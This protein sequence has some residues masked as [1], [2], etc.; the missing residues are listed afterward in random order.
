MN[1]KTALIIALL[2]LAP[3]ATVG[4]VAIRPASAVETLKVGVIGPYNLPQWHK[5]QGGMEGGALLA[6]LD[7]LGL[8]NV[9][10][11]QYQVEL[12]FADEHAYP[13]DEDAAYN[14]AMALCEEG[15]KFIIGGFRTEVTWKIIYAIRDWNEEHPDNEVIFLINGASTDE[16]ISQTV[17]AD[18]NRYKWIFRINP[19]NSTMLGKTVFGYLAGYLIPKKLLPMYGT[20]LKIGCLVEDYAWTSGI[21]YF[22]MYILPTLFPSGTVEPVYCGRSPPG[23]SDF[24]SFL[25]DA[26]SAGVKLLVIAYTLPDAQYLV[27][28]WK[29]GQ[30]KFLLVGIDVFGQMGAYPILT[31]GGC[32]YE[33]IEDFSGTATPITDFA[34]PFWKHFVGNFSSWPIYTAWGAYNAFMVLKKALET[35]GTLDPETVIA[36]L[37]AQ[38]TMVLNGKAKFTPTHDVYCDEYGATWKNGY[39]RAMMVQWINT[40]NPANSK[41]YTHGF[42]KK[43]VC[44]VDQPYSVKLK[45][46]P[47]IHPLSDVDLNFDGQV[48]I[49]DVVAAA[50]A[51]GSEP[52]QPNWNIEADVNGDGKINILDI[53]AIALKFGEKVT[54][55]PP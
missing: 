42:V 37:E 22:V 1:R 38:E 55:W 32:E 27:Q 40:E 13:L 3:F 7:G 29:S 18:Y 16:L 30:Y 31:G 47:W 4:I 53:V 43:V 39:T 19:I 48:N 25:D 20:P 36:T 28:K 49:L 15:C 34:V 26:A 21:C 52:G 50:L 35:A 2:L 54:P 51:F 5:E 10:G 12:H 41:P 17:G 44:P 46:P 8:I 11:T 24:S 14:E 6:M 23:T 33:I 9:G 45:F